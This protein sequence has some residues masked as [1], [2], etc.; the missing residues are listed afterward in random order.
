MI[1]TIISSKTRGKNMSDGYTHEDIKVL[2]E[3][4]HIQKNPAMYIGELKNPNHPVAEALDNALD[5]AN[6]GHATLVGLVIDNVNH[7]CTVSDNGRGI[8]IENNTI[9]TIATKLFSGGKF[10]KGETNQAYKIASGLHGIGLVAITALSD[11]VSIIVYRNGKRALYR[12]EN[13]VMVEEVVED[14][15]DNKPPFSTQIT[16][17]PSSRFFESLD[18]DPAPLRERLKLASVHIEH[19]QLILVVDGVKEV[20]NCD[21][22]QYFIDTLLN[23]KKTDQMTPIFDIRKRVKDEELHMKMCWDPKGQVSAKATGCINLLQVNTGTHINLAYDTVRKVFEEFAK[24]EK[25]K[26][27]PQDALVGFRLHISM[28]LYTPEYTS[29]TKEK[30]ASSRAKIAHL[31]DDAQEQLKGILEN[32]PDVRNQL[33]SFFDNYRRGLDRRGNVVKGGSVVS[34]FSNITDSKLLDCTS[35]IVDRTELF[36][37]EGA[38]AAGSLIQCREPKYHGILGLK[39]KIPNVVSMNND[40]LKNKEIVEIINALGTDI[41]DNFSIDSLRYGKIIIATDA[42]SDGCARYDI[43]VYIKN[44]R[45]QIKKIILGDIIDNPNDFKD[46]LTI[47]LDEYTDEYIWTPVLKIWPYKYF[48]KW[49]EI[50]MEDG[51]ILPLTHD[52]QVLVE[53]KGWIRSDELEEEDNI[54]DAKSTIESSET[55]QNL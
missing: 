29:Q 3:I 54:L 35:S 36:I 18:F 8:P 19:L 21:E 33:L 16:F 10:E 13:A 46:C 45:E 44:K 26:F 17:K 51:S 11:M 42:D 25:L 22:D 14:Y 32:D 34:R 23:H 9:P 38:S 24:K 39:G 31:F 1:V 53:H 43:P 40:V 6:A 12:F 2:S 50:E 49:L 28:L 37:T 20:I 15:T 48:N 5:E 4:E 30:L 52:H 27:Q 7:T 47:G 55:F 41:E